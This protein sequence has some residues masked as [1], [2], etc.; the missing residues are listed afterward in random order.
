MD[1]TTAEKTIRAGLDCRQFLQ[2]SKGGLYCCPYCGSG[3]GKN[4][5]G[6]LKVYDTNTWTCHACRQSGDVLDLIQKVQGLDFNGALE[7]AAAQMN[8]SIDRYQGAGRTLD[9]GQTVPAAELEGGLDIH[10][11]T[12]EPTSQPQEGTADYR[13]YYKACRDRLTD[14]AAVAY[15][16]A[17]G[18][19]PETARAY[20]IGFDPAADPAG[21]PGAMG[22]E[23]RPHP[24]PRLIIPTSRAHYVGRRTDGGTEYAKMNPARAK[25]AGPAGIFNRKALKDK[26]SKVIFVL[27]GAFDALSVLEQ[28]RPAVALNSASN[29]K[30]LARAIEEAGTAATFILCPDNDTDPATRERVKKQFADLA[31]ELTRRH[32]PNIT[33]DLNGAYK[34]ANAHLVADRLSFIGTIEKA[35]KAAEGAQAAAQEPKPDNSIKYIDTLL[36]AEIAKMRAAGDRKTGFHVLDEKSQGIFPGLY[37]VAATSSLGKTTFSL[38][39][40][41][42]LAAA[43]NDVLF[44]SLEQSRLELISKSFTRLLAQETNES[45][46]SSLSLR[47]GYHPDQL[48]AAIEIYREKIGDRMSIIEGNFNCN[49]TYIGQYVR[50]YIARNHCTPVVFIDY[51]QILQPADDMKRQSTKEAIDNTVTEL[52]R[53]SRDCDLTIFVISSVNRANYMTPIDFESLKESGGIEYTADVVWGLQLQ[54]LNE[55]LFN[56]PNKIKEKRER[57]REEKTASPRKIELS[58]LKNRNGISTFT[59]NFDYYPALD[60]FVGEDADGF[61][62]SYGDTPIIPT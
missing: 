55:D 36:A 59:C 31:A 24:V 10:N 27:E 53:L 30:V 20:Y 17:R 6:A 28:G 50:D 11:L 3:T 2:K 44:F 25:G 23:R 8:I 35:V 9:Y 43:G 16:K 58:C 7:Y 39:L 15:L 56:S 42:N 1:R 32:V 47:R 52:R 45:K 40:A 62:I 22:N 33:A 51:L 54:C 38:Q 18:I 41:D 37:V 19:S 26:D 12:P 5:T 4:S 61:A 14:P 49:V 29:G 60:M 48:K 21:A 46:A 34:D 13:E 57:I